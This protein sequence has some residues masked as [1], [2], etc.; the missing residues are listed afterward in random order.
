MAITV[1]IK[2]KGIFDKIPTFNE[3]LKDDFNYGGWD[4]NFVLIKNKLSEYVLL[5]KTKAR[6]ITV[7]LSERSLIKL[8]LS[9]PTSKEEISEF[10]KYVGYVCGKMNVP[11]FDVDGKKCSFMQL[12]ELIL[13]YVESSKKALLD[14]S[15][16]ILNEKVPSMYIFGVLHPIALSKEEINFIDNDLDKLA[17]LLK[18]K[19][20]FK[21]LY[22][23]PKIEK[24]EKKRVFSLFAS[25][26]CE[27]EEIN[28]TYVVPKGEEVIFPTVE[29]IFYKNGAI[30]KKSKIQVVDNFSVLEELDFKEYVKEMDKSKRYDGEHYIVKF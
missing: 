12:E 6:G 4:E 14:I 22:I 19:Q 3:I 26:K 28:L 7:W 23:A 5:Y 10:F 8:K 16:Q 20:S 15:N 9:L 1:T 27:K 11:T 2:T 21:A 29:R 24:I 13:E 25:N 30:I 18:E 17:I